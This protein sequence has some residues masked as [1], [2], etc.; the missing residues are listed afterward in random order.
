[1]EGVAWADRI[2]PNDVYNKY[3]GGVVVGIRPETYVVNPGTYSDFIEITLRRFGYYFI[4]L[5]NGYSPPHLVVNIAYIAYLCFLLYSGWRSLRTAGPQAARLAFLV[6]LGSY[7]F[8]VFHAMT[9]VEDWRYELP[10]WPGVWLLA[11][12][13]LM[14]KLGMLDSERIRSAEHDGS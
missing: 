5:R 11:G 6:V 2:V 12:F 4:P 13:G 3:L 14:D 1:M 9:F 7:Y 8:G 10:L